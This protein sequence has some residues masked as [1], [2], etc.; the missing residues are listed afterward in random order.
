MWNKPMQDKDRNIT[1]GA[2]KD[3]TEEAAQSGMEEWNHQQQKTKQ[4]C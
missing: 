2:I 4:K 1:S 3:K